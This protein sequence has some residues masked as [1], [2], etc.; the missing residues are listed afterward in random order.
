MKTVRL[1]NLS[2]EYANGHYT[3]PEILPDNKSLALGG[4]RYLKN[5][6]IKDTTLFLGY[7]KVMSSH[8]GSGYAVKLTHEERNLEGSPRWY[9]PHHLAINP[10]KPDKIRVVFDF[11]ADYHGWSLN[12]CLLSGPN[13]VHNPVNV[14]LRFREGYVALAVDIKEMFP[15]IKYQNLIEE[16]FDFFGGLMVI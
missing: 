10:K 14:L 11:A 3:N 1:V 13:V 6:L 8:I 7:C 5:R 12:E 16:P 2:I 4:L 9:L 15:Q